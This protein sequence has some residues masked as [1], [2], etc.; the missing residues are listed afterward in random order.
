M[1]KIHKITNFISDQN[2]PL[3]KQVKIMDVKFVTTTCPYCGGGCS[4]NLVV[5]DGKIIDT[6]PS[7]RSPV[8]QGKMCPKGV[9]GF[10]FITS[11]DRLTTPLVKDKAT[12]KQ[13]PATWDEALEVIAENFK[14]YKP[15]EMAVISSARCCNED[16]SEERR[17]GKECR[18]RWSPYH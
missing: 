3:L 14:K 16:R 8:N 5:K 15:E 1:N 10:E 12:G 7:Q 9:F 13:R 6:Q 11:P 17:V 2:N 18:S 4:F